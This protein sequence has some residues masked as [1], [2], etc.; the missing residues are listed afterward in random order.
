MAGRRKEEIK[1]CKIVIVFGVRDFYS[2]TKNN[3]SHTTS[4]NTGS[5]EI[6]G[7]KI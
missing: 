2:A 7:N 1:A 3:T 5:K 4:I 6:L